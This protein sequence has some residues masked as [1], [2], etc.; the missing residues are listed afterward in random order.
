MSALNH[1][2]RRWLT[3]S[4]AAV[5]VVPLLAVVAPQPAQAQTPQ[6]GVSVTL[7][8]LAT[9]DYLRE[10]PVG[11]DINDAT[12]SNFVQWLQT[13]GDGTG[14][15]G[16]VTLATIGV[17]RQLAAG[18]SIEVPIVVSGAS[19]AAD[20]GLG[21]RCQSMGT[22]DADDACAKFTAGGGWVVT[23]SSGIQSVLLNVY[24]A[25]DTDE[26]GESVKLGIPASSA[27]G[28]P[29]LGVTG[30][31]GEVT[32]SGEM[33]F[34][35]DDTTTQDTITARLTGGGSVDGA[36]AGDS[37]EFQIELSRPLV[38]GEVVEVGLDLD[39]DQHSKDTG[40]PVVETV[41]GTGVSDTNQTR[42]DSS[43]IVRFVGSDTDTV[44]TATVTLTS[45][46]FDSLPPDDE[47]NAADNDADDGWYVYSI[48]DPRSSSHATSLGLA[49]DHYDDGDASTIHD[50]TTAV[51]IADDEADDRALSWHN[52]DG[53]ALSF[54]RIAEGESVTLV[55]KAVPA[56]GDHEE[57]D[58]IKPQIRFP[59]RVPLEFIHTKETGASKEDFEAL[60]E[61]VF[62]P[63]GQTE[64]RIDVTPIIDRGP[65]SAWNSRS[66]GLPPLTAT[67][68]GRAAAASTS[69]CA[70]RRRRSRRSRRRP[71][72]PG[73]RRR[74]ARS[75]SR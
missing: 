4:L 52:A 49:L 18:E 12:A 35:I 73:R 33:S 47:S 34:T 56:A 26:V 28:S 63:Y 45:E 51:L 6:N 37:A 1:A 54:A 64:A 62:I 10:V 36:T 53:T 42:D 8:S 71:T 15:I 60:P 39:L 9:S 46:G 11:F 7:T 14:A 31:T 59:V 57:G 68:S 17:S 13:K 40:D 61:S 16:P 67:A 2:V 43:L 69:P 19:F 75:R 5:L 30:I 23:F 25:P 70:T 3:A 24:A 22:D 55:V 65:P 29:K 21:A 32:G 66:S 27:T 74:R 50:V 72:Q 44:Q 58:T 48:K 38:D 20:G 41:S